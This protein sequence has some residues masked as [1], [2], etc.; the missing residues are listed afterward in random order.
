MNIKCT[1]KCISE[2]KSQFIMKYI[3]IINYICK[4]EDRSSVTS[5]VLKILNWSLYKDITKIRV[6][7][8]IYIYYWLWIYRFVSI[9]ELIYVLIKKNVLFI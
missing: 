5:K 3:K 8:D 4:S 9:A 1:E 2:K 6:F 7:I